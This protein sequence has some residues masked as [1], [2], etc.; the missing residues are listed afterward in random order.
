MSSFGAVAKPL[1]VPVRDGVVSPPTPFRDEVYQ[2]LLRHGFLL[3]SGAF[4]PLSEVGVSPL[5][6]VHFVYRCPPL[7]SSSEVGEASRGGGSEGVDGSPGAAFDQS[8][9]FHTLEVSHKGNVEGFLDLMAQ[10]DVEQRLEAS[11]FTSK[12]KGSRE[13]NNLEYTINYDAR[14]SDFSRGKARW[15]LL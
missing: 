4:L 10:F 1:A 7:L 12:S 11:V 3:P 6:S 14:G 13:V 9:C 15:H 5:S 8:F 2:P